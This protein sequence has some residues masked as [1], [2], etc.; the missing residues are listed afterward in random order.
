[1]CA[2]HVQQVTAAISAIVPCVGASEQQANSFKLSYSIH[3][4]NRAIKN[5]YENW[6]IK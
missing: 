5:W 1:M 3:T 6:F 4:W 2:H